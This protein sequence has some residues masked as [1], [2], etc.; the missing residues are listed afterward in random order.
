MKEKVL[1]VLWLAWII[2][3]IA[4][5]TRFLASGWDYP[6]WELVLSQG[7]LFFSIISHTL[8]Y[9][10]CLR[11]SWFN[12]LGLASWV[13]Y[14]ILISI[15]IPV[16]WLIQGYYS[17]LIV[18]AVLAYSATVYSCGLQYVA[19]QLWRKY[20]VQNMDKITLVE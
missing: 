15:G 9:R 6:I 5:I 19:A 11:Y 3:G 8:L 10:L 20:R 7:F 16:C 12:A 14:T 13:T 4:N 18:F 2:S 1:K 17:N